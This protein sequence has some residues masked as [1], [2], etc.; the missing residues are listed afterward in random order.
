MKC[1][2]R[3][4]FFRKEC[5][6]CRCTQNTKGNIPE[7]RPRDRKRI[8]KNTKEELQSQLHLQPKTNRKGEGMNFTRR[9]LNLTRLWA[10]HNP[11]SD[12]V[13][14]RCKRKKG[15]K[16]AE[17]IRP[18][19]PA[20]SNTPVANVADSKQALSPSPEGLASNVSSCNSLPLNICAN[21]QPILPKTTTNCT[22][23]RIPSGRSCVRHFPRSGGESIIPP[24]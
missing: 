2:E 18:E 16:N 23:E 6:G 10:H 9:H 15:I 12:P 5:Q 17:K 21:E 8:G 20:P 19:Q 11:T 1:N 4:S 24:R 13:K 14:P 22:I 3:E 7:G